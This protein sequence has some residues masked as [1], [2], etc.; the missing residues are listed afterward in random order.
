MSTTYCIGD[1]CDDCTW[2]NME[3]Q[4]YECDQCWT[5][6]MKEKGIECDELDDNN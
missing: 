4:D 6:R 5:I 3:G 2:Q 1:N